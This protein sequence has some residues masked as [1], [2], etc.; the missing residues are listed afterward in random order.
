MAIEFV[1]QVSLASRVGLYA[2]SGF[3]WLAGFALFAAANGYLLARTPWS[4]IALVLL[5][6]SLFGIVSTAGLMI[7]GVILSIC[8]AVWTPFRRLDPRTVYLSVWTVGLLSAHFFFLVAFREIRD[9]TTFPGIALVAL[10][11]VIS[12]AI[13]VAWN[14]RGMRLAGSRRNAVRGIVSF[15]LVAAQIGIGYACV[16]YLRSQPWHSPLDASPG[17]LPRGSVHAARPMNVL[18]IS[19]DTLRS[20]H[21]SSYGYGRETSPFIDA[22]A[23]KGTLFTKARSE[24]PW[25]LPSHATMFTSLYPSIHGARNF[26]PIRFLHSSAIDHLS[27]RNLTLAEILRAAGYQTNAI[28]SIAWLGRETGMMQGFDSVDNRHKQN[29]AKVVVDKAL[30]VLRST[31]DPFFLFIHFMN[32]HDYAA[33]EPYRSEWV[34]PAYHGRLVTRRGLA[35]FRNDYDQHAS[36]ADL[37]YAKARYDGAIRYVDAS[38]GRLFDWL[39]ESGL[40]ESTLVVLCADHGEEIWDH[41]GAGHGYALW[42]EQLRVPLIVVPPTG[43]PVVRHRTDAPAGIIDVT[44]TILD[45]VGIPALPWMQGISLRS[46]V[47]GGRFVATRTFF[48]ES[49]HT[50]YSWAIVRGP[51]KYMANHV[52]PFDIFNLSYLV[53]NIRTFYRFQGDGL[54]RLDEDPHERTNLIAIDPKQARELRSEL[55]RHILQSLPPAG[56]SRSTSMEAGPEMLQQLRSLGYIH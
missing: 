46:A 8:R 40:R 13:L 10:I 34:D 56:V 35:R 3:G 51:M 53:P 29:T 16:A 7:L 11:G 17:H 24:S 4:K 37:A 42:E 49:P 14:I 15:V 26:N 33:P 45:Y 47:E 30:R 32:V 5:I 39:D 41:G 54:Y 25:T 18:L 27:E 36:K 6:G 28:T 55:V 21:L 19:I 48:A 50:R 22:L 43:Y 9:I 52:P 31:H 38:L 23:S 2:G 20:D 1:E 44:P 12:L